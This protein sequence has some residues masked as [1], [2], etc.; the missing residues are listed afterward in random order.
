MKSNILQWLA[1]VLILEI[2]LIH[3]FTAQHEFEEAAFLGYL[4]MANFLGA[5]VAAYGI[6]RK[7]ILGWGLAL[8]IAAGSMAGYIWSRTTGLP[9]L[10]A[11]VWLSPWGV[12]SLIA[13]SLFILLVFMR[14]WKSDQ[15][16]AGLPWLHIWLRYLLPVAALLVLILVNFSTYQWEAAFSEGHEHDFSV[17]ALQRAPAMSLKEFEEQYGMQVSLVGV[18]ALDSIVDV[19][20][21]VLDTEKADH[22]LE[23]HTALLVGDTLILPPHMHRH[24]LK[25]GLPYI[26]FYPNPQN[27]VKSGTSVS[28]VFDD[29]RLEPIITQ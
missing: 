27:I 29:I 16:S 26:V 18:S 6:Y 25:Q 13:E 15:T 22:L 4:F 21:M 19:R 8:G 9:G 12:A 5:L 23:A 14:P 7:Q 1:I 3:Y 11:E 20:I 10:E 2:G 28:L 24:T 17:D